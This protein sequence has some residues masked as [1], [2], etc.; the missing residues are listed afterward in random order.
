MKKEVY[1]CDIN[2]CENN[3]AHKQKDMDVIFNTDQTEGRSCSPYI[4]RVRLDICDTCLNKIL[5]EGKYIQAEGA[6]GF[7]SYTI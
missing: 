4:S 7:N 3:P 5:K 1:T 2:H 6:Q